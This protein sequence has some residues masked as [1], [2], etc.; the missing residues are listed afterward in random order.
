MKL[1]HVSFGLVE[2]SLVSGVVNGERFGRGLGTEP[3]VSSEL[4]YHDAPVQ[5]SRNTYTLH[6]LYRSTE[7]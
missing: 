4:E 6:L 1:Y 7:E 2:G 3:E 5:C